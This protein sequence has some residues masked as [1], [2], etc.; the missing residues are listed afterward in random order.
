MYNRGPG[1]TRIN[2]VKIWVGVGLTG[3]NYD[4]ATNVGT[5]K[6]VTGQ[7]LYT[8]TGINVSGSSVV[9]Q[10]GDGW[11]H[12]AEVEVYSGLGAGQ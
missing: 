4:A 11:L 10:G 2:N 12:V 3:G 9:L 6:Y 5:I 8:F 7:Q 1:A